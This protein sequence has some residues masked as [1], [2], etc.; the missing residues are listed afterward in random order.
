MSRSAASR[1]ETAFFF[2]VR[3]CLRSCS[4]GTQ[5][6]LFCCVLSR[7]AVL[8]CEVTQRVAA[9]DCMVRSEPFVGREPVILAAAVRGGIGGLF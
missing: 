7:R 6:V 8:F 1:E 4:C 9:V 5:L 2:V 3:V